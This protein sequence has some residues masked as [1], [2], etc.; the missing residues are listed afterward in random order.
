MSFC[1]ALYAFLEESFIKLIDNLT[2]FSRCQP[3]TATGCIFSDSAAVQFFRYPLVQHTMC[4]FYNV[5]P[6]H[7]Q[8][9]VINDLRENIS[10]A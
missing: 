7:H 1:I 8:Q 6:V 9:T 5:A 3:N 4:C 10:P 2:L